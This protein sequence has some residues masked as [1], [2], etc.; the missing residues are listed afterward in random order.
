MFESKGR[1]SSQPSN[2]DKRKAKNQAKCVS[3]IDGVACKLRIGTFA[4]FKSEVLH[5]HWSDPEPEGRLIKLV[6]PEQKWRF[7]YEPIF[8]LVSNAETSMRGIIGD[9]LQVFPGIHPKVHQL[10]S[11]G[12]WNEAHEL[13]NELRNQFKEIGFQPDGTKIEVGES[14]QLPFKN[15]SE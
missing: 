9:S 1:S 15:R 4:Y 2:Y 5:F 11:R 3:E 12:L 10:L 7:C 13:A 14:W 6:S 8:A